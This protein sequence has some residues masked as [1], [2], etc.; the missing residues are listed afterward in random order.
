MASPQYMRSIADEND[1]KLI[2]IGMVCEEL[3]IEE[4]TF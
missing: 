4:E 2:S 1:L 3:G